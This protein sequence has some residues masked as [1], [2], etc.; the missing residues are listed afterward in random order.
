M[1][2]D[3][4]NLPVSLNALKFISLAPQ[5]H[6]RLEVRPIHLVAPFLD[7]LYV[8]SMFGVFAGAISASRK[9]GN[10]IVQSFSAQSYGGPPKKETSIDIGTR[11]FV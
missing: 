2:N 4:S 11:N 1:G 9:W 7:T 3:H 8:L 10:Y 5:L 6:K